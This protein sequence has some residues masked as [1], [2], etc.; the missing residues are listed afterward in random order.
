MVRFV[1][2]VVVAVAI[3]VLGKGEIEKLI[4][5]GT[6]TEM[7]IAKDVF[8]MIVELMMRTP[9]LISWA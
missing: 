1:V 8:V 6:G 3:A 2:A 9:M 7:P 5:T 4:G